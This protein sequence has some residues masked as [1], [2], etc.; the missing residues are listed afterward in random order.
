MRQMYQDVFDRNPFGTNCWLL[1][2][3]GSEDA[4]L[5]DPGFEPDEIQRSSS[6]SADDRGRSS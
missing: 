3:D 2:A 5:V 1:G 4:V 6:A